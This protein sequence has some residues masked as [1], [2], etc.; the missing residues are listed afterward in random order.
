MKLPSYEVEL[1][2]QKGFE[3]K[4]C[5]KCEEYF[6]TL[7]PKRETCGDSPCDEYS[8]IGKAPVSKRSLD[9]AREEYISF[10][11]KEGHTPLKRYPVVARWRDDVYFTIASIACFQPWVIEGV[12]DPPANPLVISQPCIRFN[13]IDN[14]GKTG[15]H[16]TL[17]EMMAH[18][19]FNKKGKEVYFKDRTVELCY[20]FLCDFGIKPKDISFKEAW[21]EG[22][23]NAGPCLETL[24]HGLELATLVFM[25]FVGPVDGKYQNMDMTVVDT[26]YGLERLTWLSTGAP[27]AYDAVFGDIVEKIR[28]QSGVHKLDK[29]I[30]SE[31]S[32]VAGIMNV[33]TSKDLESLRSQAAKRVGMSKKDLIDHIVPWENIYSIADHSRAVSMMIA[34]GVVPSNV[35]DGY[36]A[37]LLIRRALRAMKD[38]GLSIP[39]T[40]IVTDMAKSMKH[41]PEV[42]ESLRTINKILEVEDKRFR[43]SVER[44][45]KLVERKMEVIKKSGKNE[46]P[47]SDLIELYDSHGLP[48]AEVKEFAREAGLTEFKVP[49]DFYIRVSEKHSKERKEV[50]EK[51]TMHKLVESLKPTVPLYYEDQYLKST[52]ANVLKIIDDKFVVLDK[53]IFYPE[54]GGQPSDKGHIGGQEVLSAQKYGDVIVHELKE[55]ARLPKKV[56]CEIFWDRRKLLMQAH[57]AA[58]IINGVCVNVLGPHVWQTGA[59]KGIESSRLDITHYDKIPPEML[60]RIERE[61]NKIVTENR[62]IKITWMG[63]ND[64]EEKYGFRLYQGGAVP[65]NKIRVVEIDDIE[66]CGGL[67]GKYTGEIGLVKILKADR[68]QDGVIRL[69]FTAGESALRYIQKNEEIIDEVAN[70]FSVPREMI[71]GTA[72]RFFKEWMERGK[73]LESLYSE[74]ATAR[75]LDLLANAKKL[76][77]Y[78]LV[79][80]SYRNADVKELS[81]I[82]DEII[83]KQPD[84]AAVLSGFDEDSA[85]FLIAFGPSAVKLGMDANELMKDVSK[86]LGGGGGGSKDKAT[87]GGPV[88]NLD[89]AMK[90]ASEELVSMMKEKSPTLKLTSVFSK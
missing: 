42:E 68:I 90:K 4:K 81:K 40:S 23:G 36:F 72:K 78:R 19:A 8:F 55:K 88:N 83:Q 86:V 80:G 13:D 3:R 62:P 5:P 44:G 57:D 6:W 58:H 39:F 20:D 15:R 73:E 43:E 63:R 56:K 65:G 28:A 76:G 47:L 30:M 41:F 50:E 33:E 25:Q 34:D 9:K 52:E 7:D 70:S 18:H 46:L 26:G 37:R 53:T 21:W 1:F 66:A 69:E 67:H 89:A 48:P 60:T 32:K 35:R 27:T 64:A 12:T 38:I 59:Q 71:G 29:K 24:T 82:A 45:R 10:F 11:A 77:K 51:S 49:D 74:L 61:A 54:G 2:R 17:F 22:G 31:Y 16:M 14:V 87:G 84:S 75:A 79:S 85:K